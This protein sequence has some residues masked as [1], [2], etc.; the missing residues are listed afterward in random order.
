ELGL[1]LPDAAHVVE[2]D[3]GPDVGF[4]PSGEVAILVAEHREDVFETPLQRPLVIVALLHV[5]HAQMDGPPRA[6]TATASSNTRSSPRTNTVGCCVHWSIST[7][8]TST[9]WGPVTFGG[10]ASG[11]SGARSAR[12]G[13]PSSI[14]PKSAISSTRPPVVMLATPFPLRLSRV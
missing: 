13:T 3:R 12:S 14:R 9:S 7:A 11:R 1:C 4:E 2:G 5:G 10:P 8:T 6:L